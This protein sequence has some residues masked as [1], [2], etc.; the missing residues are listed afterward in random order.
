MDSKPI[1]VLHVLGRLDM[2]G[3]ENRI[4]DLYRMIDRSKVQFD[5]MIH[6]TDKCFFN[7]EIESLG[8]HIYS[9]PRYFIKNHLEYTKAWNKFF[10]EHPEIEVVHGHMTSTA[11]IYL[12]IA[13]KHGVRLSI[14]H[15]RSAGVPQGI[16]GLM[17]KVLRIGL[18][19]KADV[20][21][22]CSKLAGI[23]SFGNKAFKE[24]YITV[25]PNAVDTARF[26]YNESVR[27]KIRKELGISDETFVVGHVGRFHHAKNHEFL[28]GIF[29]EIK[30]QIPN[31]KLVLVGDGELREQITKWIN[32]FGIDKDVI[33]TG[34]KK[35]VED[36]Y[37]AFDYFV[38]PS[39]YEGLPGTVV[40]AQASG[41]RCLISDAVTN[42][43][44]ITDLAEAKSLNDSPAEWAGRVIETRDYTRTSH[45]EEVKSKGFDSESQIDYYTKLYLDR[46]GN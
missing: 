5:F 12:P 6:T 9:V 30:K 35:N 11:G 31:S 10:E 26:A 4:M 19:K 18:Y 17:T 37:Q 3:A 14:A 32:E 46:Q 44:M 16:K 38:F 36:Y 28:F 42:E 33:L 40:E 8:G 2:G 1:R 15:T 39:R 45:A 29:T 34:T 7:G 41:L 43:V 22:A 24:G 20:C 13:R 21:I 25:V 23:N 27:A